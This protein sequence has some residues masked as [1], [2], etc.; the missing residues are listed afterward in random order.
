METISNQKPAPNHSLFFCF[1]SLF[2]V[3]LSACEP[4]KVLANTETNFLSVA[5]ESSPAENP[6]DSE[7]EEGVPEASQ[8]SG[9]EK[10]VEQAK[11]SPELKEKKRKMPRPMRRFLVNMEFIQIK[12][13]RLM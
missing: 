4:S 1:L 5:E 10:V 11:N 8:E 3:V 9:D 12:N 7:S 6:E 13:Y 2:F